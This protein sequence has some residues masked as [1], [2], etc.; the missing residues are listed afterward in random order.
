MRAKIGVSRVVNPRY[1]YSGMDD[2]SLQELAKK[3]TIIKNLMAIR[4]ERL[5][6]LVEAIKKLNALIS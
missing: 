1:T 3:E 6:P 4:D 5:M 2:R